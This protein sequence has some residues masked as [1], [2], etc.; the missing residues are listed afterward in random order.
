M[1]GIKFIKG[2][3]IDVENEIKLGKVVLLEFWYVIIH[4]FIKQKER[5]NYNYFN[6]LKTIIVKR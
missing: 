1:E 3:H 2:A 5:M 4:F 6:I